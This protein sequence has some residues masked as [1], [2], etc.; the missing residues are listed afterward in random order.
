VGHLCADC[1]GNSVCPHP[2][3]PPATGGRSQRNRAC[4]FPRTAVGVMVESMRILILFLNASRATCHDRD[5]VASEISRREN[6]SRCRG[7]RRVTRTRSR[8]GIKRTRHPS[9]MLGSIRILSL[10]SE[11]VSRLASR[12]PRLEFLPVTRHASPVTT[13]TTSPSY[14]SLLLSS[15]PNPNPHHAEADQRER[16]RFGDLVRDTRN[17]RKTIIAKELI[18]HDEQMG[19]SFEQ[20]VEEHIAGKTQRRTTRA[21]TC[22]HRALWK[23]GSRI[24]GGRSLMLDMSGVAHWERHRRENR[25]PYSRELQFFIGSS[26]SLQCFGEEQIACRRTAKLIHQALSAGYALNRV[27]C[28]TEV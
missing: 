3:L 6:P 21:A 18:C 13:A 11:R 8:E 24:H 16:R 4:N 15:H 19:G 9:V 17:Q 12:V 2:N 14:P 7:K 27:R 1:F 28:R 10:V 20:A 22:R 26:H 23:R 25:H 5:T